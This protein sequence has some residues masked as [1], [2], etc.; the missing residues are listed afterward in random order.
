MALDIQPGDF[1]VVNST[2][3]PIRSVA[4]YDA[5]GFGDSPGFALMASVSCSTKRSPA[6]TGSKRGAPATKLSGLSCTPLDPVDPETAFHM[7]MKTPYT[8]RQTF[9]DD[10]TDY[11]KL[12][13][14]V[15]RA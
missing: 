9:I 4:H 8:T 14:D 1:L 5:H 2:E 12:I 3:Y 10:G 11:A 6:V 13:L 7:Q 15:R